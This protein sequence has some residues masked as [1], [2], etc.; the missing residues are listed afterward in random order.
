MKGIDLKCLCL[1]GTRITDTDKAMAAGLGVDPLDVHVFMD[2]W[3]R[4]ADVILDNYPPDEPPLVSRGIVY[5]VTSGGGVETVWTTPEGA[6]GAVDRL[7]RRASAVNI[8]V[9]PANSDDPTEESKKALA[10]LRAMQRDRH[11]E[12]AAVIRESRRPR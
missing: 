10:D 6:M 4:Y 5:V 7:D 11:N 2:H 12:R 1:E 3:E 8:V 9:R